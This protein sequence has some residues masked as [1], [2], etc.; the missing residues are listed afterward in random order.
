M[1]TPPITRETVAHRLAV[2]LECDRSTASAARKLELSERTVRD[3]IHAAS[4]M[5]MMLDEA[6]MPG[7]EIANVS[8]TYGKDGQVRAQSITQK[9]E[10][11]GGFAL[12]PGHL[13][14]GVSALVDAD[15]RVRQQWYK[16]RNGALGSGLVEA[17]QEAFAAYD[18]LAPVEPPPVHSSESR[19]TFYPVTDL[20]LGMLAWGEETGEDWDLKIASKTLKRQFDELILGGPAVAGDCVIA[21]MGDFLHQNDQSNAT[22]KS[23]HQLDVDGRYQKVLRAGADLALHIIGRAAQR[24]VGIRVLA[25]PGNHDPEASVAVHLALSLFYSSHPRVTVDRECVGIAYHRHGVNLIGVT[26]GDKLPQ[27][28]MLQAMSH[29]RRE[30][31]SE[32]WCRRFYSGHLHH[33]KVKSV[34]P[35]KCEAFTTP[36]ARDAYAHN[37]GYRSE[38]ELTAIHFDASLGEVGR[39]NIVIQPEAVKA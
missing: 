17:L 35:L 29:D 27:E 11:E 23:R 19:L 38:R 21:F 10:P 7:F 16:T 37:A 26:H 36:I 25:V 6:V 30:D 15:G 20:H 32:T 22:P 4:R 18:G 33:A 24:H 13:I 1:P 3:S 34:G 2:W 28:R 8:T 12:P 5:G 39:H 31:W 14:K 9:P